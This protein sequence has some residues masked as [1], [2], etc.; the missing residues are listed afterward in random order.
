MDDLLKFKNLTHEACLLSLTR[1]A[2]ELQAS[3][4]GFQDA[5]NE[6]TKSSAGDKYETGRAMMHLEKEKVATQLD[7]VF[8]QQKVMHQIS[9]QKSSDKIQLGSFLETTFGYFYL[10]VSLGAIKAGEKQ[11]MCISPVSPLGKAFLDKSSNDS[12]TFN[13]RV[14]QIF[15]VI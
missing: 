6:E 15:A 10:S 7:Q 5:A 3:L 12:V 13:G 4:K 11:V 14:Y 2:D 1:R 9:P 8:K